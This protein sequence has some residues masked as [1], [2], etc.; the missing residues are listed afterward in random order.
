M[1]PPD[2]FERWNP[3]LRGAYRKGHE[4]AIAGR[5]ETACPYVDKR[6]LSGRLT[7][8]RSF[9]RA[10]IDGYRAARTPKEN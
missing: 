10:W 1:N 9:E 2:G 8:S 4:A 3:A 6:T 5:P 7:W